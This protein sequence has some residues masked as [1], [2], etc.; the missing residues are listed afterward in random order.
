VPAKTPIHV[1]FDRFGRDVGMELHSRAWF[2]RTDEVIVTCALQKSQYSPLYYLNVGYYL[3]SKGPETHPKSHE[4]HI[5]YR[6]GD[7]IGRER[8]FDELLDLEHPL[9]DETR[10]IQ[11]YTL[12]VTD[13][14]PRIQRGSTIA[15]SQAMLADGLITHHYPNGPAQEVLLASRTTGSAACPSVR[16]CPLSRAGAPV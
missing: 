11:L 14:G 3:R 6:A 9:D 7:L 2:L 15:G 10:V 4:C 8:A 12:L 1:A 13:L 5:T 16:E